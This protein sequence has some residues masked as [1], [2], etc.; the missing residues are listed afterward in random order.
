MTLP[1][2]LTPLNMGAISP[3]SGPSSPT[4]DNSPKSPLYNTE[5][6]RV[7]PS[8]PTPQRV[9]RASAPMTSFQRNGS[10]GNLQRQFT[11]SSVSIEER[12][13]QVFAGKDSVDWKTFSDRLAQA[14]GAP[15]LKIERARYVIENMP[16]VV[17][18]VEWD[19]FASW[20]NP[21][22]GPNNQNGGW[23]MDNILEIVSLPYFHGFMDMKDAQKTLKGIPE[24]TYLLR[25][26]TQQSYYTL[27]VSYSGT[28]GHWRIQTEKK[29]GQ[30]PEFKV[31]TRSYES[32]EHVVMTHSP[33]RGDPLLIKQPK[34]GQ[35]DKCY[36]T[37]PLTRMSQG[38]EAYY[39]VVG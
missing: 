13:G 21:L 32:L 34:P 8:P 18:K 16:G 15:I 22:C 38:A 14:M 29:P 20:F 39:Q 17:Y 33:G 31:E 27:S 36:L 28:V 35:S 9:D 7:Q 2:A 10:G 1:K 6:P 37:A 11:P 12:M 4:Y 24:G 5:Q 23:T 30:R 3:K 25:F 19:K 26:S